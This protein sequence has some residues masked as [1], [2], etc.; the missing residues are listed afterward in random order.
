[1]SGPIFFRRYGLA[2]IQIWQMTEKKME[3]KMFSLIQSFLA[4]S[5][6]ISILVHTLKQI[7]NDFQL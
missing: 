4:Y 6:I 1:M 5:V 3:L 2:S 7:E